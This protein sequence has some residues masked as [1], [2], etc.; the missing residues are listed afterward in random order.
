MLKKSPSRLFF[1]IVLLL[2]LCL[3]YQI[4]RSKSLFVFS[5]PVMMVFSPVVSSLTSFYNLVTGLWDDYIDLVKVKRRNK[6]LLAEI[7]RLKKISLKYKEVM[8]ENRRLRKLLSFSKNT[9]SVLIPA[10]V[11]AENPTNWFRTIVIN[12]GKSDGVKE[13]L[14]VISHEGLVG[15]VL[16]VYSTYAQVQL[17]TDNNSENPETQQR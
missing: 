15:K 11:I 10:E 7:A 6:E 8:V 17:I 13:N 9:Q 14:T 1:F 5:T 4:R 3:S 12:K 2:F 16:S